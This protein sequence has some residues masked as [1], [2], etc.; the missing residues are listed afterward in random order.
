LRSFFPHLKSIDEFTTSKD[1]TGLVDV[2]LSAKNGRLDNITNYDKFDV[3]L[4]VL[5]ELAI[6]IQTGNKEY[7]GTKEF[8]GTKVKILAQT[9]TLEILMGGTDKEYGRAMSET[10]D[11][12][13]RMDLSTQDWYMYDENYGTS[14][15]KYFIQFIRQA[16]EDLQKKYQQIYLLRNERL[17]KIYRFSDGQAIEPDFVLFLKEKGGKKT[18]SYQLFVEPKGNRGLVEDKW[19]EDFLKEV[20]SEFT[21]M[22]LFEKDKYK[23]IG[24]PFY[25]ETQTKQNFNKAFRD[26]LGL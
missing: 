14:E 6:K 7:V 5:K 13:L 11:E 16:M 26:K 10:Q 23:L 19:K 12:E 21:I 20:E 15:E 8:F 3:A 22:T 9:K 18:L 17:F 2:E 4:S 24:L 1:F 25:N